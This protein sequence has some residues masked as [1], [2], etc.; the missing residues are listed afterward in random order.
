MLKWS[1]NENPGHEARGCLWRDKSILHDTFSGVKRLFRSPSRRSHVLTFE[2]WQA[3]EDTAAV[4]EYAV[5]SIGSALFL[6][7]MFLGY[8]WVLAGLAEVTR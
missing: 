5:K 7:F 3:R 8:V 6:F 1:E 4:L 2:E